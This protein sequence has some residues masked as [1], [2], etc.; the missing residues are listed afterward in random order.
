MLLIY[1]LIAARRDH[2]T[3]LYAE[4]VRSRSQVFPVEQV[5]QCQLQEADC[6]SH[7]SEL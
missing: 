4:A 5:Q 6:H 2:R 1:R 7:H 3:G